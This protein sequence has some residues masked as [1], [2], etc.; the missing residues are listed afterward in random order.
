M[1]DKKQARMPFVEALEAYAK[2]H[3]I[4]FHTPGHKIGQEAP[5]LLK[6]WMGPALP[7]DLG[8]MYALDDLHEPEGALLEAEQLAAHLYRAD[9]TLFSINGTTG[10]IQA[11]LLGTLLEGDEVIIPREAHRSISSSLVLSGA[12][13]IYAMGRYDSTYGI[14]LGT[15]P[16]EIEDLLEANPRVKAI[17]L[18]HPNYYGI[19]V[20]VKGIVAIAHARGIPVLVDEAHGPHLGFSSKLPQ[21]ALASGADAVSQSTHKLVGSLTQTSMLHLQGKL[22][23]QRRIVEAY[24]LLQST[25]PNYIFLASLD[26]ARYQLAMEGEALLARTIELADTL[27]QELKKIPG[28]RVPDKDDFDVCYSFDRTK[29]IIDFAELGLQAQKAE[30][31]L[32]KEKIEVELMQGSH[33]LVLITIGDTKKSIEALVQAVAHVAA[34]FSVSRGQKELAVELPKPLVKKTPR[35]VFEGD[36]RVVSLSKAQGLIAAETISYYPPGIPFICR[37]EEITR[38]V[39]DYIHQR[40]ALGYQPNGASDSTLET[41]RVWKRRDV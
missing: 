10:A 4:P 35:D 41:I 25:S 24:Q 13:P 14:P 31:L 18:V 36:Y 33:V 15:T 7:Y 6:K 37:G 12:R 2:E 3:F 22:L 21:S 34:K 39:I 23:P 29:V 19:G 27:R 32:R 9:K 8:L 26:M 38:D 17:V 16:E 28:I 40:Q 5:A 1:I 11:M 20:D 30:A